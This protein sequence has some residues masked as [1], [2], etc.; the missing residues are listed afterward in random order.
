MHHERFIHLGRSLFVDKRCSPTIEEPSLQSQSA[1]NEIPPL[2]SELEEASILFAR[3]GI[4]RLKD[5][6]VGLRAYHHHSNGKYY[7]TIGRYSHCRKDCIMILQFSTSPEQFTIA[8]QNFC[9]YTI[10]K[11]S[12]SISGF[13]EHQVSVNEG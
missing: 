3:L 4:V 7:G 12:G 6:R 5:K 1:V 11:S 8:R 13:A 10:S 9:D 2:Y